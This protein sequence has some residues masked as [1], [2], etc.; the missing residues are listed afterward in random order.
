MQ[1]WAITFEGPPLMAYVHHPGFMSEGSTAEDHRLQHMD[2]WET[3]PVQTSLQG[4]MDL[5]KG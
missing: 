1:G 3:F 2:L 4:D 5:S